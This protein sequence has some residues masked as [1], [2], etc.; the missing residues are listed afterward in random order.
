VR[1]GGA[2]SFEMDDPDKRGKLRK[3]GDGRVIDLG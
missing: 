1:G 2:R 3:T